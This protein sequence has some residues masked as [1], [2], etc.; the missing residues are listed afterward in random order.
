MLGGRK[1]RQNTGLARLNPTWP[2]LVEGSWCEKNL[3]GQ[4]RPLAQLN[5]NW[6][7]LLNLLVRARG[8]VADLE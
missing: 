7:D 5:P 2:D 4:A 8:T 6:P 1:V 3:T